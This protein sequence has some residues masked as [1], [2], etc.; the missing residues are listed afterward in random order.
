MIPHIIARE[1]VNSW[2]AQIIHLRSVSKRS[3][4]THSLRERET[5]YA[6]NQ[7]LQAEGDVAV[8]LEHALFPAMIQSQTSLEGAQ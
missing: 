8:L 4:P 1:S 6:Q 2:M 5:F 7:Q 3:P